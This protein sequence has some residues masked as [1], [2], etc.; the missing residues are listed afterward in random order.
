MV[1]AYF[2]SGSGRI[3]A[4]PYILAFALLVLISGKII[5]YI[6]KKK[7]NSVWVPRITLFIWGIPVLCFLGFPTDN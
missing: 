7:L 6:H 5:D 2:A 3:E 1:N 4:I